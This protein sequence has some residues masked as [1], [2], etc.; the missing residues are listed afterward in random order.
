MNY[1]VQTKVTHLEIKTE[2]DKN[3]SVL[4]HV[5]FTDFIY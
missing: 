4:F 2:A 5:S 3:K 1:D